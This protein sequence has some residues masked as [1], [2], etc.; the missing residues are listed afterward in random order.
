MLSKGSFSIYYGGSDII[1]DLSEKMGSPVSPTFV[2][3]SVILQLSVFFYKK[4]QASRLSPTFNTGLKC[5]KFSFYFYAFSMDT[6]SFLKKAKIQKKRL[7]LSGY[8]QQL[9]N[10]V[11]SGLSNTHNIITVSLFSLSGLSFMVFHFISIFNNR[12]IHQ[13]EDKDD[14]PPPAPIIYLAL[15]VTFWNSLGFFQNPALRKFGIKTVKSFFTTDS[16]RG[17]ASGSDHRLIRPKKFRERKRTRIEQ[18]LV[19]EDLE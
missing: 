6:T 15:V 1:K 5:S 2:G 11:V 16:M 10:N 12:K 3:C 8:L 7:I 13:V 17:L 14:V 4:I 18:D 19:I 9:R